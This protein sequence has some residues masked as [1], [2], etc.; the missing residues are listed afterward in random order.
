M[1]IHSG[2]VTIESDQDAQVVAKQI[3]RQLEKAA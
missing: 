3:E 1:Y 2:N